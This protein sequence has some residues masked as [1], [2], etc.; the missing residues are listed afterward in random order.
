MSDAALLLAALRKRGQSCAVAE[1]LTGGLLAATMVDVPGASHSFRGGLIVYATDLKATL[2]LV[3][4]DL[5]AER[6][7]VDPDVALA[8]A[9]GARERCGADWGISTTGVAG[10]QSQDGHPPGEAYVAVVGPATSIV[11][12]MHE[13]GDRDQVR[14]SA[15]RAALAHALDALG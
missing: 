4:A 9:Q 6:G 1:S 12:R 11:H 10:P 7:P 15:V 2:A 3:P 5:L 13:T 14:G 8:M